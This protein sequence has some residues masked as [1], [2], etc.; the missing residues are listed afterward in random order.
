MTATNEMPTI[1]WVSENDDLL[2]FD[3]KEDAICI[4]HGVLHQYHHTAALIEAIEGMKPDIGCNCRDC[5]TK[6]AALQDI[7]DYLK[8]RK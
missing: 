2:F 4:V 7:Q 8:E 6:I 3:N 1:G 5:R